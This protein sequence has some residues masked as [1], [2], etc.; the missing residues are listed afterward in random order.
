MSILKNIKAFWLNSYHSDKIAF[1]FELLSFITTVSASL[2]LAFTAANPDMTIV[3]P[4]FFIGS[5]SGVYAYYRR[6]LAW[7]IMLTGYFAIVNVFG[8]GV[9][10]GWW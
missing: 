7:P 2:T 9:A 4:G 8:Y 10:I 1:Y 6:K 3:Y 5:L